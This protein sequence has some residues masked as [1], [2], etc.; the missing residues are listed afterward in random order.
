MYSLKGPDLNSSLLGILMWFQNGKI[1]ILADIQQMFDCFLVREDHRNYLRFLSYKD[2]DVTKEI[3]DYRM[4]VH[5]FGNIPS[6]AVTIYGLRR[7]IKEGKQ[8]HGSDPIN[9]V[10]CH[11]YMDNGLHSMPT[12]AEAIDLLHRTQT[13]FAE[14]NLRLH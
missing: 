13:S 12:K 3:I 1:A 4:M 14:L 8:A 5:V 6:P 10:G 2:N 9:F 7:A 11:F